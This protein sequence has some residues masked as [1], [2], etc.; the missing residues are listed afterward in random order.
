MGKGAFCFYS[1][2]SQFVVLYCSQNLGGKV[3]VKEE[4]RFHRE[5]CIK[6][7]EHCSIT[8]TILQ[9]SPSTG[10][11]HIQF[12]SYVTLVPYHESFRP[13]FRTLMVY[14]LTESFPT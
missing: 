3:G 4:G 10:R 12:V 11:L 2:L 5:F 8:F 1:L 6:P 13:A 9:T 7:R 14:H